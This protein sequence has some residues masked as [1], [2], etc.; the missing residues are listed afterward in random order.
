MHLLAQFNASHF[1][2][3]GLLATSAMI[4]FQTHRRWQ[5]SLAAKALKPTDAG[6]PW[7]AAASKQRPAEV[8][9]WEVHVHELA[10]ET[11]AR[12]DS[13]M[14]ALEHLMRTANQESLRL[15]AAIAHASQAGMLPHGSRSDAVE[16]V[17]IN[18]AQVLRQAILQQGAHS[19]G[20]CDIPKPHT[21]RSHAEIH[22]LAD[23]GVA[24]R[25]IAERTGTPEGEVQLILGLRDEAAT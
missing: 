10:R 5:R 11:L 9:Q 17:P 20:H 8:Q 6:K 23:A 3:A 13:K 4:L 18:Q 24:P 1:F 7:Q 21:R 16:L 14:A 12:I 22:A 19:T 15:E 2:L 25:Q